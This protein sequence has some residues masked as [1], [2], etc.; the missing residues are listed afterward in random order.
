MVF[1]GRV[2][3]CDRRKTRPAGGSGESTEVGVERRMF[4]RC[5]D[6]V[7][8]GEQELTREGQGVWRRKK[9]PFSFLLKSLIEVLV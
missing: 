9:V 5:L 6:L 3:M 4:W 8:N 7:L 2:S 1:H